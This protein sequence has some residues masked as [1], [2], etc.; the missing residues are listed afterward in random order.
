MIDNPWKYNPP[1]VPPPNK[2]VEILLEDGTITIGH[3]GLDG[4][5]QRWGVPM[6][7]RFLETNAENPHI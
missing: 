2:D 5:W 7:W 3:V 1:P 6:A 4:I